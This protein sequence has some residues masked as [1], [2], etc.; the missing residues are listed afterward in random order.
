MKKKSLITLTALL[1]TTIGCF[2]VLINNVP[3]SK[4]Y[5]DGSN[6]I[7][8]QW[9]H[10][11][12]RPATC[13]EKGI[14]EYWCQCGGYYQFEAPSSGNIIDKGTNYDT[15]E[16]SADDNRWI[17]A[18]EHSFNESLNCSICGSSMKTLY[19]LDDATD[20]DA[21][22]PMTLS[23]LGQ[24]AF[25][26]SAN[27]TFINYKFDENGSFEIKF[28]YTYTIVSSDDNY[29]LI[30]LFNNQDEH[31]LVIRFSTRRVLN[32]DGTCGSDMYIYKGTD[33]SDITATLTDSNGGTYKTLSTDAGL[34][35]CYIPKKAG[36]DHD[37]G[38]T[39]DIKG[40]LTNAAN[41]SYDIIVSINNQQLDK[42]YETNSEPLTIKVTLG[43]DYFS[44]LSKQCFRFSL[45]GAKTNEV[46]ASD[47]TTTYSSKEVIYKD[48]DGKIYGKKTLTLDQ[49]IPNPTIVKEGYTF[50]GWHDQNGNKPDEI[51][52]NGKYIF[53]P[54]FV[55]T[56]NINYVNVIKADTGYWVIFSLSNNDFSSKS[57]DLAIRRSGKEKLYDN[58]N[59]QENILFNGS[60]SSYVEPYFN[61]Y[62]KGVFTMRVINYDASANNVISVNKDT[63]FPS[64]NYIF[65]SGNILY[66]LDKSYTF[67]IDNEKG[68]GFAAEIETSVSSVN[69]RESDPGYMWLDIKL[70]DCDFNNLSSYE[71]SDVSKLNAFYNFSS[72]ILINDELIT[73]G[74]DH[75]FN[76][77]DD[78][79]TFRIK[80][81]SNL[82]LESVNTVTILSDL[83]MP[84]YAFGKQNSNNASSCYK[85]KNT[86]TYKKY[87]SGTT[88]YF[89]DL[90]SN[91]NILNNN[92]ANLSGQFDNEFN[93]IEITYKS[94]STLKA[95]LT[96]KI[97]NQTL[98]DTVYLDACE[99]YQTSAFFIKD[100]L[101]NTSKKATSLSNIQ[102]CKIKDSDEDIDAK[103]AAIN[104]K[105]QNINTSDM[106][107][108]TSNKYKFGIS[109][110][111]GGA[112][113]YVEDLQDNDSRYSNLVNK[114]DSGRL[115]QQSYYGTRGDND[116]YEM[117]I[118]DG[119]YCSYNPIQGG[120]V[121][122]GIYI[123]RLIDLKVSSNSIYVKV[124]PL[125]WPKEGSLTDSY[126]ADLYTLQ[127]DIIR[128]DNTFTDY[129]CYLHEHYSGQE[130][131]AVYTISALDEL[132]YSNG[133]QN[134]WTR[135]L[136]TVVGQQQGNGD[137][138]DEYMEIGNSE[139][140]AGYFDSITKFGLG[141]YTPNVDLL[142]AKRFALNNA[143]GYSDF[144][145][146][147]DTANSCNYIG[148]YTVDKMQNYTP[149]NY[150]YLLCTGTIDEV[151]N[152]FASYIDFTDNFSFTIDQYP[153][154]VAMSDYEFENIY[155]NSVDDL[156]AVFKTNQTSLSYNSNEKSASFTSLGNDPYFVIDM[157]N[158]NDPIYAD[159]I[160]SINFTYKV[161]SAYSSI[162]SSGIQVFFD[163]NGSGFTEGASIR[164]DG[165]SLIADNE[166]HTY[167]IDTSSLYFMSGQLCKVRIDYFCTESKNAVFELYNFS[168]SYNNEFLMN[169][170][171]I[172]SIGLSSHSTCAY[173]TTYDCLEFV[174]TGNDPYFIID[175]SNANIRTSLVNKVCIEYMIPSDTL[176]NTVDGGFELF[177]N[178][179]NA[180]YSSTCSISTYEL[181]A[182]GNFHTLTID[183][184]QLTDWE[185]K[186][187]SLRFDY[188]RITDS[189]NHFLVKSVTLEG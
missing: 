42:G 41:Y 57:I 81:T 89:L 145:S 124:Q 90:S 48:L 147:S 36:I 64:Y 75:Y 13:T 149:F 158:L 80:E 93:K 31:G 24:S 167:S 169:S 141:V 10:Y 74:G 110:L 143:K 34:G 16:F 6:N 114:H 181:I 174:T 77:V 9:V 55:I 106:L 69:V 171:S 175:Y 187:S 66:R 137:K 131:P 161:D 62:G 152:S 118:Y 45:N 109:L 113:T 40:I 18:L 179:N 188:F 82:T 60:A 178:L 153:S 117:V 130:V 56:T 29:E 85:I 72:H 54:L 28:K 177:Y 163:T 164:I 116:D 151:R 172:N 111:Y 38:A 105:T 144:G 98:T 146:F 148:W 2:S 47:A 150:S 20:L 189:G 43:A 101:Y 91:P 3:N 30:Y 136:K 84:T 183:L 21:V 160:D 5:A 17:P 159:N 61:V 162:L 27:H 1:F 95:L 32:A 127:D 87:S 22:L 134:N 23:D 35:S 76:L 33:S 73:F 78:C 25:D 88:T 185:G 135:D 173:N 19:S 156:N 138:V 65:E 121:T 140:W 103:V 59:T 107:Y 154:R 53:T 133:G 4:I 79:F 168:L 71:L 83:T 68:V 180:G 155:F 37:N 12:Q 139:T 115:I 26:F 165:S 184:S 11:S 166:Y 7:N 129:S 176:E 14:R 112:I 170:S 132:V 92:S 100:Y 46:H 123:P 182:D 126:M 186:I 157:S 96:Y 51:T 39:I 70:N 94:S 128:V 104:V 102:L 122:N 125:D 49:T 99:N 142:S 97:D 120:D 52:E 119:N 8:E 58:L 50:Y 44:S 67:N 108:L 63:V 15:S 86:S